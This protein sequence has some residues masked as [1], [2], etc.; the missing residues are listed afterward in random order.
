MKAYTPDQIFEILG[1]V[2]CETDLIEIEYYVLSHERFYCPLD[3]IL[4]TTCFNFLNKIF[5]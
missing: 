4:F 1:S 3:L 5:I 2:S